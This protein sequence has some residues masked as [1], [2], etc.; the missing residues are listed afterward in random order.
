MIFH[1]EVKLQKG[2]TLDGCAPFFVPEIL[3][4]AAQARQEEKRRA[5]PFSAARRFPLDTR[6]VTGYSFA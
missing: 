1:S 5:K 3:R 2:A 6:H 4:P